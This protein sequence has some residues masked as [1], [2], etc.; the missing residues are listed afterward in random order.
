M[1][2]GN[3]IAVLSADDCWALLRT[4]A[5]GRLAV[6]TD[7]HPDIFPVNFAVDGGT[8]VFRTA[9]GG[10]LTAAL[11]APVA[12]EADGAEDGHA[13]SVV[14]RGRAAQVLGT[15]GLLDTLALDLHPWQAGEKGRFVRITPTQLSGRRFPVAADG[16]WDSPLTGSPRAAEE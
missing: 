2:G 11:G 6:V 10:K 15:E 12:F 7:G 3:D 9:G 16:E 8:V 1:T 14:L 5:V 4:A 13:W